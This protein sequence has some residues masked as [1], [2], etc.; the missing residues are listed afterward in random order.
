MAGRN[1]PE[2]TPGPWR[3]KRLATYEEPGH[4]V[5]WPDKGGTHM[6][7]LDYKGNFLAADA[8]LIAASPEL[9]AAAL[10]VIERWDTP[11]WKEVPATGT[12][13]DALRRA[14][15]KALEIGGES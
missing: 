1:S 13:I 11:A 10:A 9:L 4:V 3:A 14:V 6:R 7:R 12:Y 2:H 8:R 15:A 5:L